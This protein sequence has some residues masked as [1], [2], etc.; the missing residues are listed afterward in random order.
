MTELL[1]RLINS[2]TKPQ[3]R[4]RYGRGMNPWAKRR[5][6]NLYWGESGRRRKREEKKRKETTSI[7]FTRMLRN[8][9]GLCH[10]RI[11]ISLL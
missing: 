5:V 6:E 8:G 10:P 2:G 4:G 1:T 9:A 7:E 11:P 3:K